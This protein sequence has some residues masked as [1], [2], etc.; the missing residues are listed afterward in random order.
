[1]WL[2]TLAGVRL[3]GPE[4]VCGVLF[5]DAT[6]HVKF[7]CFSPDGRL[8]ASTSSDGTICLWDTAQTKCLQIL[9]GWWIGCVWKPG[10]RTGFFQALLCP[11][12]LCPFPDLV[13]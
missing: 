3:Q 13:P 4:V 10:V 6:D 2:E 1:M 9:K 7:C 8:F 5:P 12:P 11:V